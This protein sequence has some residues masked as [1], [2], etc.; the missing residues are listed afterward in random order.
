MEA[1][2]SQPSNQPINQ[3]SIS[4]E[5]DENLFVYEEVEIQEGVQKCVHSLI[6]NLVTDKFINTNWVNSAMS[7][8]CNQP[9][10]TVKECDLFDGGQGCGTFLKATVMMQLDQPIK[11]GVNIGS[12]T[13]GI[14]WVDFKS[15]RL[16][17]FRYF[18]GI[19]GH[20]KNSCG[21]LTL[22]TMDHNKIRRS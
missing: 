20:S 9:K 6:G 7:N 14:N 16:P 17:T 1:T 13:N 18:C 22:Q 11:K 12:T 8:M 19:I 5:E 3:Q 21:K 15:E 10:G 2:T 4:D